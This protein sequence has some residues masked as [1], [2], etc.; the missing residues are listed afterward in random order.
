M[1]ILVEKMKKLGL[2]E[3]ELIVGTLLTI[4]AMGGVPAGVVSVDVALFTNPFVIGA[5]IIGILF[6]GLIGYMLFIR[7]FLLYRKTPAV[8][9]E[10]DGEY[11][12]VHANK[13]AKIPLSALSEATIDVDVPY[14]LRKEFIA[15]LIIHLFSEEYGDLYLEVPGYGKYRM[16]FVSHVRETADELIGYLDSVLNTA[17]DTPAE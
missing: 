4:V 15:E 14:L 1:K 3:L 16:R 9:V 8:Q 6:F 12:Y 17:G 7:P 13:E 11:L 2:L 10:T 5:V